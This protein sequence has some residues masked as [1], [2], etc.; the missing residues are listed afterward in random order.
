MMES[1]SFRDPVFWTVV[2]A[3]M[4]LLAWIT[5]DTYHV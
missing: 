3:L 4:G 1:P 2:A 5:W